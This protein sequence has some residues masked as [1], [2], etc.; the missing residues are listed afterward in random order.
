[1]HH[2]PRAHFQEKRRDRYLAKWSHRGLDVFRQVPVGQFG[3]LP[4][5]QV[6]FGQ[7]GRLRWV[8]AKE[9]LSTGN[10]REF[11]LLPAKEHH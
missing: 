11:R 10:Q 9:N 7:V 2:A 4:V 1:M 8:V 6:L 5:L 3:P